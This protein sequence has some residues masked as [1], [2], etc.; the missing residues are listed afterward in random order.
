MV[1]ITVGD[2]VVYVESDEVEFADD[3]FEYDEDGIAWAFDE[4]EGIWYWWSEED[5]EWYADEFD[6]FEDE[7]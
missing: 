6:Y 7:I 5:D 4:D 3:D 1:T 2:V